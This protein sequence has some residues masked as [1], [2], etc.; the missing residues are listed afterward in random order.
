M[1]GSYE[2]PYRNPKGPVHIVTGSAGCQENLDNFGPLANF[3]AF[4]ASDYGFTRMQAFNQTHLYF[5][6]VS[7][8]Q[9]SL[10]IF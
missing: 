2:F 1:N 3:T 10:E 9:V 6:Q 8:D 4:R 7:D 5:E